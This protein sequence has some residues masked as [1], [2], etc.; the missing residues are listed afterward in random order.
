MPKLFEWYGWKD[1][2]R[3]CLVDQSGSH[4]DNTTEVEENGC[5]I[6]AVAIFAL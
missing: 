4:V 6:V 5:W 2:K 1:W 3:S